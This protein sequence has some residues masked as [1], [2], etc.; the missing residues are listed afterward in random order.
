MCGL[1]VETNLQILPAKENLSKSN[2]R[3]PSQPCDKL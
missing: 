2:H 1:H 3:W